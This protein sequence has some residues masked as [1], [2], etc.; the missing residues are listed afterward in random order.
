MTENEAVYVLMSSLQGFHEI[1]E[2][3]GYVH[4]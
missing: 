1:Y 3:F 2:K 4:F